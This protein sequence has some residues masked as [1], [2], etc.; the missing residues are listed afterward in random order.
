M[1]AVLDVLDEIA[2]VLAI[3]SGERPDAVPVPDA[4]ETYGGSIVDCRLTMAEHLA[5]D[6]SN[7]DALLD[8]GS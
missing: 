7:L 5:G 2:R 1:R 4:L 6:D 8:D 3:P